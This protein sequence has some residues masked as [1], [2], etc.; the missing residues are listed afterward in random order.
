MTKKEELA[1]IEKDI[2]AAKAKLSATMTA[3]NR[4]KTA[5]ENLTKTKGEHEVSVTAI[6]SSLE[7][8]QREYDGIKA[9]IKEA[10]DEHKKTLSASTAKRAELDTANEQLQAAIAK[11]QNDWES[12]KTADRAKFSAELAEKE[13]DKKALG[14]QIDDITTKIDDEKADLAKLEAK[15]NT[16]E[17]NIE[18]FKIDHKKVKN[19]FAVATRQLS[20]LNKTI[21]ENEKMITSQQDKVNDLSTSIATGSQQ[22]KILYDSIAILTGDKEQ[23]E[24]DIAAQ[25]GE[26]DQFVKDKFA[27]QKDRETLNRRESFIKSQYEKAGVKYQ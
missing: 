17:S 4:E 14:K 21:A 23:L 22:E 6:K 16:L 27:L 15:R 24:T 8:I 12:K 2:T 19:D 3:Q 13:A 18:I 1:K 11:D 25:Q 7:A 10:K 5:L 20:S 26:K 9:D